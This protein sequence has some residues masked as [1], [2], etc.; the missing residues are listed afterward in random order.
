MTNQIH[1]GYANKYPETVYRTRKSHQT[2]RLKNHKE[3][4]RR[5]LMSKKED[6]IISK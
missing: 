5:E 4:M 2:L 6:A 1:F 3:K